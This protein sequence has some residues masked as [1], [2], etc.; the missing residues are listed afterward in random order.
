MLA[1]QFNARRAAATRL[2]NRSLQAALTGAV[3][4]LRGCVGP[5]MQEKQE[6]LLSNP[7][8]P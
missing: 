5:Q 1:H 4:G 6:A 7:S 2:A 8:Y 3:A